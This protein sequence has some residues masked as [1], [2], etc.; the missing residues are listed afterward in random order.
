M[1]PIV[2]DAADLAIGLAGEGELLERRRASL[3]EAG[4]E[5]VSVTADATEALKGLRLLF[6]AGA[7][8][9]AS[10]ALAERAK[11]SGVLVN[12]EDETALCDFHMPAV[13]R[14]GD[15]ILTVSSG[16]KSPGLVRIIR[17]WLAERFGPEWC[18]RLGELGRA[19]AAW[20]SEGLGAE[21]IST[22][23]RARVEHA[24]WLA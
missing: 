16:G 18:A 3:R 2:L 9:E 6:I 22:R 13:L 24:G 5:P 15:L 1:L 19:R 17:E 10:A 7:G 14:R 23:T 11:A 4:I 8:R 20:R 21:E 12:V